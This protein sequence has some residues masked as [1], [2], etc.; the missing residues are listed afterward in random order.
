M[1][2]TLEIISEWEVKRIW[3]N[4]IMFIVGILSFVVMGFATIPILYLL[5][6]INLNILF[7]LS[8][9]LEILVF[10]N[11]NSD[12]VI[13]KYR[14]I[15]LMAFYSYSIVSVFFYLPFPELIDWS[16]DFYGI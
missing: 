15:F 3:Y 7:T 11:F 8:W 4:I 16:Q 2:N 5:I 6:A 14:K 10:T 1:S 12:S 9:V 13:E